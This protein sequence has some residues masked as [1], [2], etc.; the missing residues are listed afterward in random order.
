[1]R[2]IAVMKLLSGWELSTVYQFCGIW[3]R[4]PPNLIKPLS[5]NVNGHHISIFQGSHRLKW[6]EHIKEYF[7]TQDVLPSAINSLCD[8]TNSFRASLVAQ[9]AKNLPVPGSGRSPGEGNGYPFQY[10][11]LENPMDRGTWWDT[12]HEVT[13]SWTRLTQIFQGSQKT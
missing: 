3:E 2:T 1:M 7:E 10:S 6:K 4:K 5:S 12:V 9:M 13:K 8:N 11:C